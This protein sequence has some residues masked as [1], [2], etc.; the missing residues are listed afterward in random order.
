MVAPAS[1]GDVVD[2][3]EG[4]TVKYCIKTH[5]LLVSEANSIQYS[6]PELD[7]AL[8]AAEKFFVS[9]RVT[10]VAGTSPT[11]VVKLEH[12]NDTVN[13]QPRST[14]VSQNTSLAPA[15]NSFSGS[16]IGDTTV[17]G[18]YTRVTVSCSGTGLSSYVEVWLCGRSAI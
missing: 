15:I 12:S 14:L 4:M 2:R 16:E 10:G 6:S 9:V 18:R 3:G 17:G 7:G 5:D 11:V 13:W 1:I 8:A